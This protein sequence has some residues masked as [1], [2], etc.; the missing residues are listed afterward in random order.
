[1]E[2]N[3]TG[4]IT[5]NEDEIKKGTPFLIEYTSRLENAL[6]AMTTR[7]FMRRPHFEKGR[8]LE[9]LSNAIRVLR[10]GENE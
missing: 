8:G 9:I 10:E 5:I 2:M 1:M 4:K 3:L 7:A 6:I